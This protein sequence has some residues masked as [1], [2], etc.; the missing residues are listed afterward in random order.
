MYISTI[1]HTQVQ[2]LSV[3]YW[4]I[5]RTFIENYYS[6]PFD[7]MARRQ[8]VCF[9]NVET[10]VTWLNDFIAAGARTIVIRFGCPDQVGQL[11]R[12]AKEV[13]PQ[14]RQSG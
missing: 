8:S 13:L 4:N 12:C 11:E 5:L 6:V 9:G 1:Q 14:V 2:L 7:V 10:C 3:C